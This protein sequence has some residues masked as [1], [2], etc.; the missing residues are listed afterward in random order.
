MDFSRKNSCNIATHQKC[1]EKEKKNRIA[2]YVLGSQLT[3]LFPITDRNFVHHLALINIILP[4]EQ[5]HQNN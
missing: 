2:L 5:P 1:L 3:N 4:N